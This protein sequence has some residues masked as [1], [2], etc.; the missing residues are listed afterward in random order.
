MN[1]LRQFICTSI[2]S[3]Y[4]LSSL[5]ASL[6]VAP[7]SVSFSPQEKAKEIWLTNT[8]ER[9]IRAQTR[10]LIWSQVSGQDQ[11]NPT[12]DLVASPSITEIK[13][14]EQQLIR[15]IRIASQNTAVEQTYRLLIDELPSSGQADAQTGLQLLLQYSIP[16][17]IQPT[18][19]IA[20]RNGLTLLN[21]VSFQYQNQQLIVQNNAKSHIRMSEL[22]YINP[23]GERIP[24]INGLVGYALAGQTMRW[25]I[26][27]SKKILPNGKF[28]ARINSDGL[29][30][31]LPIQ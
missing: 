14:G 4:S 27:E 22:T 11:V 6:Q 20:M 13:A 7:I 1:K 29:A 26:P 30:Q 25:D 24:L 15:I 28:E 12:R 19:S 5:A 10:V 3:L 2:V 8:S 17:F 9:P 31:M 16:V 18:D 23:N 21:Q